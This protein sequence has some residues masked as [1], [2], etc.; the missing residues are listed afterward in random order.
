[1]TTVEKT[2]PIV[3]DLAACTGCG[4]CVTICHESCISLAGKVPTID[5]TVCSTC[6]QCVAVCAA[7]VFWWD[8]AAPACLERGRLPSAEQLDELFGTRHSIRHFRKA[9]IDRALLS[10]IVDAGAYAPT[11]DFHL[12]VIAVDDEEIIAQIDRF[13]FELT[14]KIYRRFFKLKLI[15]ELAKLTGFSHTYQRTA[16]KLQHVIERGHALGTLPA[17]FLFVVGDKRLPLSR[18]SAQHA[19]ANMTYAAWARHVGSCLSGNGPM[20]LD[21]DTTIRKRLGLAKRQNILG[22]LMLGYPELKFSNRVMGKTLP[23]DWNGVGDPAA[24]KP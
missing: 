17:A 14:V 11:E 5:R 12:R 19:L 1:M 20:Y 4:L 8:H 22:A 2:H 18:D 3:I 16:S 7:K 23:I 21:N 9:K 15:G 6:A 13:L 24:G 10:E